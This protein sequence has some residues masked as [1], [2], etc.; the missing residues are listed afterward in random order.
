VKNYGKIHEN[1]PSMA[2]SSDDKYLFT[3]DCEENCH[4]KQFLVSDGQMVKDYGALFERGIASITTTP[5]NKY[6][7]AGSDKGHLKQICL[8]RREVVHDYGKIHDDGIICL[9]TTRDSKWLISGSHDGH[10][11][12]ISVENR[13]VDK[14]FGQISQKEIRTIKITADDANLFVGDS[15][16]HLK[17]ISLIEGKVIQDFGMI[18]DC[19]SFTGIIITVDQKFFFTS[20]GDGELKQWNYEDNTLISD[21]GE[22]TNAGIDSLCL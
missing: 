13:Q 9:E 19:N 17:L 21:H 8:E 12:R 3:S 22:I 14:D 11:K 7:F 10:V 5:D 2:I 1:I 16:G 18:F 20:S 4:V 15:Y 6:L